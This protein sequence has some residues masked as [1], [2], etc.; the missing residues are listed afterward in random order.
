MDVSYKLF[1]SSWRDD[2]VVA[3]KERGVYAEPS[4]VRKINHVR[5]T[6]TPAI[7]FSRSDG[8]PNNFF[9]GGQVLQC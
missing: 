3:D 5:L 1:E 2:A 7:L 6:F 9:A 8:R 4:R